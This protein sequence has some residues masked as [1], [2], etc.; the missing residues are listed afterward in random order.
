MDMS[1]VILTANPSRTS[2]VDSPLTRMP[3]A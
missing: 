2:T 1:V 3:T